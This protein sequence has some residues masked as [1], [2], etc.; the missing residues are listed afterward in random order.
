MDAVNKLREIKKESGIGITGFTDM[1]RPYTI[2]KIEDVLYGNQNVD[3]Q[4]ALKMLEMVVLDIK[5][6]KKELSKN[7]VEI[8]EDL[9]LRREH[10]ERLNNINLDI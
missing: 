7:I 9:R 2:D 10:L 3:T 8:E 5:E 4:D 1:C 6:Q